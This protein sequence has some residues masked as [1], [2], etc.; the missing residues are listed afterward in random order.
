VWGWIGQEKGSLPSEVA[1][2]GEIARVSPSAR[3][4]ASV[5]ASFGLLHGREREHTPVS[6]LMEA[7][8]LAA[9]ALVLRGQ[10]REQVGTAER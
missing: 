3:S 10:P 1:L 6:A 9:G 2:T 5:T 4:V 7:A 8:W